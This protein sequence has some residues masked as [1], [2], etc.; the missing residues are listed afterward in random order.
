MTSWRCDQSSASRP[1]QP[2]C[3]GLYKGSQLNASLRCAGEG[4]GQGVC[5]ALG[6]G[7]AHGS[8]SASSL[9]DAHPLKVS[10][11]GLA[12]D[13]ARGGKAE[14]EELHGQP[15]VELL[16]R[17]TQVPAYTVREEDW[18]PAVQGL[19]GTGGRAGWTEGPGDGPCLAPRL[20]SLRGPSGPRA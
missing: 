6:P 17:E 8:V 19:R 13:S 4:T 10:R 18:A 16:T 7:F 1:S 15:R 12:G 9:G 2:Q 5:R 14:G 11:A 20:L 3:L